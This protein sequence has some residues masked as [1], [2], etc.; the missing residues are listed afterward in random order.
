MKGQD[1]FVDGAPTHDEA[2]KR[3]ID[4]AAASG[5]YR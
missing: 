3:L 1:A 5:V 2:P 4:A